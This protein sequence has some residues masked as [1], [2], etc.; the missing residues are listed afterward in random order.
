M[1]I[2]EQQA[3]GQMVTDLEDAIVNRLIVV[4][5]LRECFKNQRGVRL[6]NFRKSCLKNAGNSKFGYAAA[7]DALDK[8][9]RDVGYGEDFYCRG[10]WSRDLLQAL[11]SISA[12]RN[13]TAHAGPRADLKSMTRQQRLELTEDDRVAS[14]Y[15]ALV[16][17]S[18]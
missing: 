16:I 4:H 10:D 11:E 14:L 15:E 5:K 8:L 13:R 2:K 18:G 7:I 3:A 17:N 9:A 6:H 12:G 1:K